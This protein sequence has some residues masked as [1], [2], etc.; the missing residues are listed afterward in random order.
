MRVQGLRFGSSG[1]SLDAFVADAGTVAGVS[2]FLQVE[3]I[4]SFQPFCTFLYE[5]TN[6]IH[7]WT[8]EEF[9]NQVFFDRS[10]WFWFVQ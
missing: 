3:V 2:K 9:Q 4:I 7:K 10:S 6:L 5:G 8:G 1:G